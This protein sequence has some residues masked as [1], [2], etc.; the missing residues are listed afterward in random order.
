MLKNRIYFVFVFVSLVLAFFA[1]KVFFLD[2]F[3]DSLP[4]TWWYKVNVSLTNHNIKIQGIGNSHKNKLNNSYLMSGSFI[5]EYDN[6]L[7][8]SWNVATKSGEQYVIVHSY[9]F[10]TWSSYKTRSVST[11][12]DSLLSNP[13]L[14]SRVLS[15]ATSQW[16]LSYSCYPLFYNYRIIK[17]C[18]V[19]QKLLFNP[20]NYSSLP[21]VIQW[22]L[23][24]F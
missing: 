14:L 7:I 12:L 21:V 22:S 5:A 3:S 11:L 13:I 9:F 20:P 8:L 1:Y 10:T 2:L 17:S 23:Q 4:N 15:I 24:S 16:K 6:E 18:S 19:Y